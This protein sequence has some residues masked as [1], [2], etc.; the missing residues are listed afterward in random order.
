[1]LAVTILTSLDDA[2][3]ARSDLRTPMDNAVRLARLAKDSGCAA[4]C[5]ALEIVHS[6]S[7]GEDLC[8]TRAF[9]P[10]EATR[11]ISDA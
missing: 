5:M 4:S 1:M 8:P 7:G 10:R 6:R 2:E 11:A 3:L 9:V